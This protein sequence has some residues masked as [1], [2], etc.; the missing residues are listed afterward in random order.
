MAFLIHSKTSYLQSPHWMVTPLYS[1]I[2]ICK[3]KEVTFQRTFY[4]TTEMYKGEC[5]HKFTK[6]S[7][8]CWFIK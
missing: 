7:V 2:F 5:K 3:K 1:Q 6:G 8:A 4:K